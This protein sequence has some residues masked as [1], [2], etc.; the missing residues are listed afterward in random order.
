EAFDADGRIARPIELEEA[1]L[2]LAEARDLVPRIGIDAAEIGRIE[3]AITDRASERAVGDLVG[4]VA[5]HVTAV[6]GVSDQALPAQTPSVERGAAIFQ[7]NCASCHGA[8]GR[9]DGAEAQR[10]GLKPANF[11][12][13]AFMAAETPDDFF[14]VVTLGRRRSGMPSWSDALS[15]QD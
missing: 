12:D 9:G 8:D 7:E 6:A 15:V 2:L 14:N 10:L 1:G 4:A 3:Q 11:A 13:A 5:A